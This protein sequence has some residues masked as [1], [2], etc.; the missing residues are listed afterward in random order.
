MDTVAPSK[1]IIVVGRYGLIASR[2]YQKRQQGE[3]PDLLFLSSSDSSCQFKYIDFAK[4]VDF[5][6]DWFESGDTVVVLGAIS[7]PDLCAKY[8]ELAEAVNVSGPS[9]F[10]EKAIK[11]GA[12]IIFAST[13][14]VYGESESPFYEQKTLDPVG[15]YGNMK[16]VVEQKFAGDA[17]FKSIRLSLVYA[18]NDKFTR[19]LTNCANSGEVAEVFHPIYRSVIHI[20]DVVQAIINIAV[21]WED[22]SSGVINLAGPDLLS[23]VDLAQMHKEI[24][25]NNLKMVTVYPGDRFFAERPRTI[26]M[27]SR[28]LSSVLGRSPRPISQA[29]EL[30]FD[31]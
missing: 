22:I 23:R 17:C 4:P 11:R 19:Y 7:E 3:Y 24:V 27:R 21:K 6:Y 13:D 16:A 18:R 28:Y 26:N 12:R 14:V 5:D 9:F 8:P 29:V 30:E 20:E 31:I 2:L 25:W 10:I 15:A 1:R